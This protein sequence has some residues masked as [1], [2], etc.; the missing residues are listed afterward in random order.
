MMSQ[1]DFTIEN[2]LPLPAIFFLI[3][4]SIKNIVKEAWPFLVIFV[5]QS[6]DDKLG[7]LQKIAI[8]LA[9][10][11]AFAVIRGVLRYFN[12]TYVVKD[13]ELTVKKGIFNKTNLNIPLHRIQNI[14][15]TQGFWQQMLDITTLSVD[16]A[17]TAGKEMEIYLDLETSNALKEFLNESRVEMPEN[18]VFSDVKQVQPPIP[19]IDKNSIYAYTIPQ[20]MVA[21]ISRNHLKGLAL[22]IAVVYTFLSQLGEQMFERVLTSLESV[23]YVNLTLMYWAF[24]IGFLLVLAVVVNFVYVCLKYWNLTTSL[25]NNKIKYQGGLIK[26]MEQII[27]LNKVQMIRETTNLLEKKFRVSSLQLLQYQSF[28]EKNKNDATFN[29]PG[30]WKSEELTCKIYSGLEAEEFS[31]QYPKINYLYRNFNIY[32]LYPFLIISIGAFFN[33]N[34][35]IFSFL[36][37]IIAGVCAYLRYKKSKSEIGNDHIRISSGM[38]GEVVKT[39]KITNIQSITFRQSIFQA[40]KKTASVVIATRWDNMIIPFIPEDDAKLICNYLLYKTE[41]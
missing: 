13:N 40:R 35:L 17:G 37:L 30:F 27:N 20:L 25:Y 18:E 12:F 14:S 2:R 8:G 39:V 41:R 33:I 32:A 11:I 24:L 9:I 4:V 38:I 36:W 31:E 21:A 23:F 28:D 6:W 34:V 16:T 29:L 10:I 7:L 5:A 26:K 22:F 1:T 19:E 15:I 3:I